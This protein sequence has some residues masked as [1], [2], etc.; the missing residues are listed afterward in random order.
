MKQDKFEFE[1]F[2][3]TFV[4]V[5]INDFQDVVYV[6]SKIIIEL[7]KFKTITEDFVV[8]FSNIQVFTFSASLFSLNVLRMTST[9]MQIDNALIIDDEERAITLFETLQVH[10][11]T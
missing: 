2:V 5:E 11:Y 8:L 3:A 10:S 6:I 7:E 9:E 1:K 4:G